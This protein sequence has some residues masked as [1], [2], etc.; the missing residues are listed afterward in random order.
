LRCDAG[1]LAL[2]EVF[3]FGGWIADATLADLHPS[4]RLAIP[5]ESVESP[6]A[7]S[8]NRRCL[9]ASE[10]TIIHGDRVFLLLNPLDCQ[11]DSRR[12]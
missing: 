4:R 5:F 6:S 9:A 2:E 12:H 11:I 7:N 3:D 8:Q 10:Q 1:K